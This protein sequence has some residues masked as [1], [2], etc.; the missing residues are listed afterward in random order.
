MFLLIIRRVFG[1]GNSP[2]S[3]AGAA[4]TNDQAERNEENQP[5]A[6]AQ[7]PSTQT[8]G[9]REQLRFAGERSGGR[10]DRNEGRNQNRREDEGSEDDEDEVIEAQTQ[11]GDPTA[12]M[13]DVDEVEE[14]DTRRFGRN[15]RE[16]QAR[17]RI[18]SPKEF[19]STEMLYLYDLL[20]PEERDALIGRYR[21][22]LKGHQGGVWTIVLDKQLEVLNTREDADVVFS[23]HQSDFME[24]INGELNPQLALLAQKVKLSGDVRKAVRFQS[25]LAPSEE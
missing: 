14:E 3:K 24:I 7:Q 23:M 10:D 1:S 20:L 2:E 9:G 25:L 13:E 18:D 19:F 5:Q 8:S 11:V 16:E 6:P 21:I 22:E 17:A 4:D 12:E 15:R